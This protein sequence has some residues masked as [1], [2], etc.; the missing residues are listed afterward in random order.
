[1]YLVATANM[2]DN[3]QIYIYVYTYITRHGKNCNVKRELRH[4]EDD[5]VANVD[6]PW[7]FNEHGFPVDKKAYTFTRSLFVT[8][9][10]AVKM[11]MARTRET[12]RKE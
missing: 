7:C 11:Q 2:K 3:S 5:R 6:V 9:S 4:N 1:M 10:L 12:A 8:D